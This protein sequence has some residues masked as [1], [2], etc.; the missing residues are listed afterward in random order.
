[1]KKMIFVF[2]I[3]SL[4][5]SPFT[6]QAYDQEKTKHTKHSGT[7]LMIRSDILP[8]TDLSDSPQPFCSYTPYLFFSHRC[9]VLPIASQ[10]VAYV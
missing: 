5:S 8:G 9:P 2:F 10:G 7:C 3:I 4:T 6:L 1:M